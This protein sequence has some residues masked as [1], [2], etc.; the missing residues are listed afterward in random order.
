MSL[1]VTACSG[2]VSS[3]IGEDGNQGASSSSG[4][5]SSGGSSSGG[6]SSGGGRVCT[7]VTAAG[8]GVCSMTDAA[9]GV[10]LE[11]VVQSKSRTCTGNVCEVTVVGKTIKLALSH[12]VCQGAAEPNCAPAPGLSPSLCKVPPLSEGNYLIEF[13]S[14]YE[15]TVPLT[16]S[17]SGKR[18]S[19][20]IEPTAEID[21]S[22]FSTACEK[23]DDCVTVASGSACTLCTCGGE[24][25]AKSSLD[26][27]QAQVTDLR[28]KCAQGT[29]SPVACACPYMQP[30]CSNKK[31]TT[32]M[33]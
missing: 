3:N 12:Q 8:E 5:S 13:A 25:I 7:V 4:G 2:A 17:A 24:A 29:S 9:P 21:L 11:L 15:A 18:T 16:V 23:D 33:D 20:S 19:C 27:Y 30:R 6:S 26:A 32:K 10:P 22:N 28:A 14:P 31:C 1:V